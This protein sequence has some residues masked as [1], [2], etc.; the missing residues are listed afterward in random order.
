MQVWDRFVLFCICLL[1][2]LFFL[3]GFFV[4]LFVSFVY[5]R[6][7]LSSVGPTFFFFFR[8]D[9]VVVIDQDEKEKLW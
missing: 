2:Y 5:T 3:C 9:C 7:H 1:A 6:L 4:C 8:Q